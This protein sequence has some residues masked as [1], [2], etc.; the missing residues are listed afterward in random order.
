MNSTIFPQVCQQYGIPKPVAEYRF[1]AMY[2]G[3]PGK[4][5][6]ERLRAS[7]LSD[8][9]FDWAWVDHRVALE[10]EGGVFSGGR[11]TRGSG[12]VGDMSKYNAAGTLGWIVL[13]CQP[14][15]LL[16]TATLSMVRQAIATRKA[17]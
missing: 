9:R 2:S 12:F 11:H 14:K 3:G 10:V 13:R 17:A 7:G 6:R 15:D 16:K 4:G 5:L 1:G 8:W